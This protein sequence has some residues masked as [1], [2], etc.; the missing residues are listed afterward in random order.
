M[1]SLVTGGAG[2]IG[3]HLVKK[4]VENKQEVI[5]LDNFS[6]GRYNYKFLE[7]MPKVDIIEGSIINRDVVHDAISQCDNIYHLAAFNRVPR[8]IEDPILSNEINITGT[9]NILEAARKFDIE[10]IVYSS[11]SSVY[12]MSKEFPRVE[13]C[14]PMP[15][16][17]YAVGKLASEYYCQVYEDLY[18]IKVK[19][20]R[21]FAVYGPKQ[22]PIIK[23]AAVIPYFILN[24]LNGRKLPVYGDGNQRRNF[25]FVEDTVNATILAMK[26][27]R[28]SGE[29]INIANESEISLNEIIDLL[30]EELNKDIL[31]EYYPWRK[32][33][34]KHAYPDLSKMKKIL[35]YRSIYSIE[36]G[37]KTTLDWY[38]SNPSYFEDS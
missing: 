26:S 21:Y 10:S 18:N 24:A 29:I 33:D 36:K 25:T 12:G 31:V 34:V 38:K 6:S 30:K 19:I 32:G 8:S 4:L 13:N 22:S 5:V 9:L 27:D 17:P 1:K 14:N 37:I 20:L 35:G 11:S 23:Y 2:F 7:T 3:S 16:S 15:K 28:A